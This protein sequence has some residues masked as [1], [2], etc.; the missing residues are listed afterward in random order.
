MRAW[1]SMVFLIPACSMAAEPP[2]MTEGVCPPIRRA[3]ESYPPILRDLFSRVDKPDYWRLKDKSDLVSWVHELNHGASFQSCIPESKHGVYVL[4]GRAVILTNPEVTMSQ[5]ASRV[6]VRDRGVN[7]QHYLVTQQR[8]WNTQPLYLLDEWTAY[9]H[10]AIA[11]RQLGHKTDTN[12]TVAIAIEMERY[13]RVMITV[14]GDQDADYQQ[15]E[16]LKKF[17]LWNSGRLSEEVERMTL[18]TG[19]TTEE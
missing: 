5:V 12:G 15:T 13:C 17:I 7:F 18:D 10:G 6:P 4:G 9:I 1:M 2:A 3:P 11:A 16:E 14:V 8:D 19:F